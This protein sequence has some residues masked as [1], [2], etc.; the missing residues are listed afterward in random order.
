MKSSNKLPEEVAAVYTCTQEPTRVILPRPFSREIDLRTITLD[1]A[2]WL[3]ATG[4]DV[5]ALKPVPKA[6]GG[7]APKKPEMLI[8]F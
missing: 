2:H 3:F 8:L 5:L 1:E 7:S 4:L 6:G